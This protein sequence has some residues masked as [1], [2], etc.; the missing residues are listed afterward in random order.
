MPLA[1]AAE[2][3]ARTSPPSCSQGNPV[4]LPSGST[5]GEIGAFSVVVVLFSSRTLPKEQ[6]FLY[7]VEEKHPSEVTTEPERN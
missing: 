3:S 5:T 4:M 2:Q 7:P 1:T 6:M